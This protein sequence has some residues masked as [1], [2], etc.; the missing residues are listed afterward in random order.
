MEYL[1]KPKWTL[2]FRINRQP[3]PPLCLSLFKVLPES[4]SLFSVYGISK[5]Q[6]LHLSHT[7]YYSFFKRENQKKLLI[8]PQ[9][10]FFFLSGIF[11]FFWEKTPC[12]AD[13]TKLLSVWASTFTILLCLTSLLST[14]I[15]SVSFIDWFCCGLRKKDMKNEEQAR[16]LFGISLSDRPKWQQFLICSSGFFFG[17]LVNGICEVCSFQVDF[18]FFFCSFIIFVFIKVCIFMVFFLCEF[19]FVWGFMLMGVWISRVGDWLFCLLL[20]NLY[21][22]LHAFDTYICLVAENMWEKRDGISNFNVSYCFG[23]E[24]MI[25]YTSEWWFTDFCFLGV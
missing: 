5:A 11:F 7:Y 1:Q 17:Y 13:K 24:N 10:L 9:I 4:Q 25:I 15:I 21:L 20:F 8:P 3:F 2:A 23:F 19:V 12:N 16:S 18:F 6:S 14:I 22:I